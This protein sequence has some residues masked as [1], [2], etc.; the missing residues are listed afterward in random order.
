MTISLNEGIFPADW[1][2]AN[3]C[4]IYKGKGS[5]ADLCNNRPISLLSIVNKVV[6]YVFITILPPFLAMTFIHCSMREDLFFHSH[7][8]FVMR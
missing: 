8:I 7:L 1:G 2:R 3:I 4:P 5:K 6:K